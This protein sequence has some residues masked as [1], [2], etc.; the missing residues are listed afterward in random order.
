MTK[1]EK[2][3][4]MLDLCGRLI[5]NVVCKMSRNIEFPLDNTIT[6]VLSISGY[7]AFVETM[8]CSACTPFFVKPYLRPMSSM[9]KE[10]VKEFYKIEDMDVRPVGYITPQPNWHFTI[11]GFDWLNAHHF[12]YRGLIEK[13]LALVA[14]IDM[15]K[16]KVS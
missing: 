14:P 12:D 1:E 10:E 15:Y 9:T 7:E 11:M 5:Y 2:Y 16:P 8:N 6:E 3:L 4:L 13:G